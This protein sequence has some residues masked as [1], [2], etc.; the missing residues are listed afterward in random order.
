LI[1][2]ALSGAVRQGCTH[3]FPKALEPCSKVKGRIESVKQEK[4]ACSFAGEQ[5]NRDAG[6]NKK[7]SASL[8]KVTA[9]L[10]KTKPALQVVNSDQ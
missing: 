2:G 4:A 1:N 9:E 8:Q 10:E 6:E 3:C 5:R 7:L